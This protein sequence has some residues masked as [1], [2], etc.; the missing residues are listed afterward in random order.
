M[1]DE[2]EPVPEIVP[3]SNG[4]ENYMGRSGLL[5]SDRGIGVREVREAAAPPA[6]R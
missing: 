6:T 3:I 4:D 1:S 2:Q 5:P